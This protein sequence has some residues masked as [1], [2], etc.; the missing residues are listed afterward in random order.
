MN[1]LVLETRN[2]KIGYHCCF[3]RELNY[4]LNSGLKQ[5]LYFYKTIKRS[6][7]KFSNYICVFFL[8][9]LKIEVPTHVFWFDITHAIYMSIEKHESLSMCSTCTNKYLNNTRS[10]VVL[11]PRLV[12]RITFSKCR[13]L[14]Q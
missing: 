10:L 13:P 11:V 5:R 3:H 1:I 6:I 4:G 8:I 7:S 12:T 9:F 2:K 14:R